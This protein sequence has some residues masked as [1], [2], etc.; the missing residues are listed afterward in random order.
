MGYLGIVLCTVAG[1]MNLVVM[2]DAY[3]IAERATFPLAA[4]QPVGEVRP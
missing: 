1:M 2:V 4:A 3:T